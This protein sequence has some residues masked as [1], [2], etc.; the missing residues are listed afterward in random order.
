MAS[1]VC[2][3]GTGFNGFS[4]SYTLGTEDDAN[5]IFAALA[6]GGTV[7][8]P[9][10]ETFRW[11]CFGMFTDRFGLGWMIMVAGEAS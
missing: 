11:P 9:L 8:M 10:T 7:Q 5:R 3:E 2:S 6:E 4:L 1:G